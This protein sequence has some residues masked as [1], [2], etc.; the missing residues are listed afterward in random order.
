[1]KEVKNIFSLK[2]KVAIVT[3]AAMGN[4]RSIAKGLVKYGAHVILLDVNET[5]YEVEN[6]LKEY[7]LA[8]AYRCDMSILDDIHAFVS[9]VKNNFVSIDILVN[10]AGVTYSHEILEYPIEAWEKTHNINLRGPFEMTRLIGKIMAEQKSGSIINITSLNSE[11]GFPSNPA[12]ISSKGALKQLTKSFAYDLGKYGVRCN[13][14]GPGY[15][16][17]SMTSKSWTDNNKRELRKSNTLLGRWGEPD[18][19]MGVTIFL[20]SDASSYITGQDI[21]VDGGWLAKGI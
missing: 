18:D 19:L 20:A 10:N 8:T 9:Y 21:Y 7:G 11:V 6:S 16:R 13:N 1:M 4:G 12:Y 5:V 17:T 14:V 15:M 2:N 3:G